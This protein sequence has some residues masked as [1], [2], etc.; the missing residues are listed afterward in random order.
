MVGRQL[1]LGSRCGGIQDVAEIRQA[2]GTHIGVLMW[3]RVRVRMLDHSASRL[4]SLHYPGAIAFLQIVSD[5]HSRPRRRAGLGPEYNFG[6]R[7]IPTDG[8]SLHF[9]FHGAHVESA[10]AIEVLEDAGRNGVVVARLLLA[11]ACKK[12]GGEH[13]KDL[14]FV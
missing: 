12:R 5:L 8:N 10:D 14:V 4:R 9:H 13:L 6:V 7:L 11:N 2:P 3:I 1:A